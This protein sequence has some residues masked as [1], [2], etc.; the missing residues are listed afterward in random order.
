MARNTNGKGFSLK[1]ELFNEKKVAYLGG[2]FAG[3]CTEFNQRL[4][5]ETT[6]EDMLDLELKQRVVCITKALEQQ[7]PSDFKKA[8][9][10]I[11]QALPEPLSLTK[12]DD[13]FGS[14]IFAPLGEYV[15]RNGLTE[16]H[17]ETSLATLR[18]ITMRFSMEDAIRYFLNEFEAETMKELGNWVDDENYHVRR[19]VSE[20]TRPL[21]PWSGRISLEVTAPVPFLD[22]LHAD[23]TRYVTRSV[24][25]HMN[26]I[27]K[28]EPDLVVASLHSWRKQGRQEEKELD[29]M[30]RHSLRTLLKQGHA[31]ALEMLGYHTDPRVEVERFSVSKSSQKIVPG[32]TLNFSFEIT[33]Q[34]DEKLMVDYMID[35]VKANGKTKPKVFKI[36]KVDLKKGETI[37]VEKKHRFVKDAT[38]FTFYP[39]KHTLT[40]QINGKKMGVATFEVT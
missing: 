6:M 15:V 30:T 26:D 38:T 37:S 32:D 35:F 21:L 11:V 39:G 19:L 28:I 8:A 40:L 5:V 2:L 3:E 36:K 16:E 18:E 12:T 14:F 13:D 9:L 25:N 10:M 24:A 17:L 27:A 22:T 23:G 33:A 31:E 34:H 29:W 4:F 20:G 7:L 1:D